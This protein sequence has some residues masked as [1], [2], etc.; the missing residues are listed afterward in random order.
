MK[1][2]ERSASKEI[3]KAA[4]IIKEGG[5]VIYPTDTVFGIG[6][7]WDNQKAIERVY[8]IKSR[9]QNIPFPV[10]LTDTSQI[11]G[12]AV[13]TPL[14]ENLI[15]RYWPGA[16]TIILKRKLTSQKVG[17]RVPDNNLLR[18][19]IRLAQTPIIGTSAN[20]HGEPSVKNFKDLDPGLVKLVDYV[21][22]GEC[23]GGIES[24][25][26]DATGKKPIIVR[27]GAVNLK[28][29]TLIIETIKREEV[30][31]ALEDKW[32]K[33]RK[34][35]VISQQTGSQALMPAIV[36]IL[37]TSKS[38]VRDLTAIEVNPGPGSFTGTRIGV[39]VANALGFSLDIPVNGKLGK[40]A[41]PKYE[42]SKFD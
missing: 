38:T 9:P 24:T 27:K 3:N 6:A 39:A 26:V 10:L 17:F 13:V 14:A 21:V 2:Q 1:K 41:V 34:K 15:K 42:K 8:Q 7:R 25:V 35:L 5:V 4:Y 31:V 12:F 37:K 30:V 29:L 28:A 19:I 32:S 40:I 22:P 11:A 23:Q 16:L 36:K 18:N 20:F 33:A